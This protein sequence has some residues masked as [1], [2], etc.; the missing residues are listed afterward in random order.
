MSKFSK[1]ICVLAI[2]FTVISI[3]TAYRMQR[4]SETIYEHPYTVSNSARAMRSRLLDMKRFVNIFLTYDFVS[5]DNAH[6]LFEERYKLQNEAIDVLYD[7]YLGPEE[8]LNALR[9]AFDALMACQEEAIQF[10]PNH[11]EKEITKYIEENVYP[12]YDAVNDCLSTIIDFA[13]NKIYTL[14]EQSEQT[15]ILYMAL[16]VIMALVIISLTIY[17]NL[18]EQ[19]SREEL[20]KREELQDALL[21]AQKASNAKR[22]FL[23]R[24]SHEIRTPMNVVIGMTAI[25]GSHLNDPKRVEDCLSKIAFSSKHLLSLINDVLDMSKIEDDKL[26]ISREPFDLCELIESNVALIYSQTEAKG[27]S[28]ECNVKDVELETYIGD[29]LRV[30]QILLNILSNAVKFTP[31]GGSIRLD[32]KQINMKNGTV[33]LQFVISDTGIGMSE[34][35][36]QRIF[37]PFE[38]ADGSTAQKYGGTGLGMAITHNLVGL[39]GG[40]IHVKSQLGEGSTFT[41][42]LPFD[43]PEKLNEPRKWQLDPLQ[44]LVVDDDQDTCTHTSLLLERM[45]ISAQWVD[46]GLEAVKLVLKAHEERQDYDVCLV[47]WQMPGMDGVEV[48]RRIRDTVGP[49]TLIIIISAY[50]WSEIE[51]E[52]RKAGV[53]AFISK[54]LFESTLY[55]T[56]VSV[57]DPEAQLETKSQTHSGIYKDRHILV[58]EDNELNREIAIEL[59][60]ET[61]AQIDCAVNGQDALDQFLASSRGYYD[62]ILMDI[63]M[64]IMNGYE[65]TKLLRSSSHPDAKKVPILAMTANAFREDVEDAYNAGMTGHLAKP[66]DV[67]HL[68]E[69]LR[70][71]LEPSQM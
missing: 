16:A 49:D 36:L 3:S 12:R 41:V 69:V 68:Y 46:S 35:F 30:N 40:S 14:T 20:V 51:V 26:T 17:S 45:G 54:P 2:L 60:K 23:A 31:S 28:F 62:L 44:V 59:L 47:D 7:R 33:R 15:S 22:D 38:Q 61:G 39:L 19:K 55:S 5:E 1:V 50:D 6:Q 4:T 64:P 32:I 29:S 10:V 27:V 66:I 11:T 34:E 70:K 58:A 42:E 63:Q 67:A 9:S 37:S 52:A 13:D 71:I 25:A 48:T 43:I 56:L 8:D 53:N 21:L 18:M 24:M 57:M 65:A